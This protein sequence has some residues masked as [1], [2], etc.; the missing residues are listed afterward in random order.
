MYRDGSIRYI[1][2]TRTIIE[3]DFEGN[4]WMMTDMTNPNTTAVSEIPF[5]ALALGNHEWR[6]ENDRRCQKG[7]HTATLSLTACTD[8]QFTCNDG[9]CLPLDLRCN[10]KPEC[11]D[12]SDE[13]E[14][15][16]VIRDESYNKFL[17]PPPV[18]TLRHSDIVQINV[19][20]TVLSIKAFDPISSTFESQFKVSLTWFDPRLSFGNLRNSS[21]SNLMSPSEKNFIWFPSFLYRNTKNRVKSVVDEDSAISVIKRGNSY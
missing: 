9:L 6:I 7:S 15:T 3:F 1:G 12:N 20:I 8:E 18:K 4:F 14:C 13:L 19:T 5:R 2:L 10:G 16:I 17:A 21:A 11:K